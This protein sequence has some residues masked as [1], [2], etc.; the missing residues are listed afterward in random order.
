MHCSPK[1]AHVKA[2]VNLPAFTRIPL[3]IIG[4][5]VYHEGI[6]R[7]PQSHPG[8][9]S[10]SRGKSVF[11][12]G[13]LTTLIALLLSRAA[14]A[15]EAL[16]ADE[17]LVKENGVT[18]TDGPNLLEFFRKRSLTDADRQRLLGLIRQLGSP[19]YS[20][21]EKASNE[22][23]A[24]GPPAVALLKPAVKDP[25][26]EIS[27][28]AEKCIQKIEGGP[29]PGLPAA[30]ARLLVNRNPP[31]AV[32][33]L[34]N[35]L[36]YAEDDWLEE[37]VL[38]CIGQLALRD[39]KVDPVLTAAITDKLAPRRAAA[40]YVLGRM[41]D[42]GQRLA[43]RKR[44][45]DEDEMV[46]RRAAFG[47]VGKEQF[48]SIE[49]KENIA[50]DEKICKEQKVATD[51]ASLLTFFRKRTLSAA[52]QLRLR[53]LVRQLGHARYRM[54]EKAKKE[55]TALGST[56][57]PFLKPALLDSDLE[58]KDRAEKCTAAI[59][60][61][62]ATNLPHAAVRLLQFRAP[63]EALETLL[64]YVPFADDESM[65]E[66]VLNVLCALSVREPKV[67]PALLAALRDDMPARRGAAAFVLGK[68]GTSADC[69]EA[70]QLLDD[71]NLK[72]RLRASQGLL[73][74]K[75][76]SAIPVL[77]DLLDKAPTQEF[78]M[79]VEDA[80]TRIAG[81]KAPPLSVAENFP[82]ER[83]K[84]AGE[85]KKWWTGQE[86][87]LNLL[88]LNRQESYLG[89]R[90]VCEYDTAGRWNSGRVWECGRD[91]KQRWEITGLTYPMDAQV[92]RNGNIL[93]AENQGR[94][95]SERDKKG[96]IKW[97]KQLNGNPVACQRLRNG[98][99]FIACYYN[100][101]EV[102]PD[103]TEVYNH[104]RGFNNYIFSAHKMHNG[105][106]VFMTNMGTVVVMNP[107]GK[108]L[109]TFTVQNLGNWCSVEGLRNGRFLIAMMSQNKVVEVDIKG[110]IKKE[111]AAEGVHTATRLP[112]GN[113]LVAGM[114]NNLIAE[115][116][117]GGKQVWKMQSPG[118]PW[119]VH[120]R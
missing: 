74:A 114:N 47:L 12:L 6:L 99:T 43:V 20:K 54:R 15:D 42:L 17:K 107:A 52:D 77:V 27:R 104:Q 14:R 105:N 112:N 95:V 26:L 108:E 103:G 79:Q 44:L 8:V 49:D 45:G 76:K 18:K 10:M 69:R 22:L 7:H 119:R 50:A 81:D 11:L 115:Y 97:Q 57:L 70:R 93:I 4:S 33:V 9:L 109:H 82:K 78:G 64:A 37:E 66:E 86:K 29:G 48:R 35:Y 100:V 2:V 19:I 98:N 67:H 3:E 62:P 92:L 117:R 63:P 110:N 23:V 75:D 89:I 16:E 31:G 58:I 55:L 36:P 53:N 65:E 84:V 91:K 59:K 88:Q 73:A 56:A 85:W 40:A 1:N 80:L 106:I 32:G 51:A 38:T 41:G 21:R 111:F 102:K 61:G 13:T 90:V 34:L 68:V 46:R 25:D 24:K 71:P 113:T 72:T 118:R 5:P 39:G 60:S 120:Y 101:M 94:R 87:T 28:R 30:A 116:D 96:H 83:Q